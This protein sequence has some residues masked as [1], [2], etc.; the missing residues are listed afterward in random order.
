[1]APIISAMNKNQ[2]APAIGLS[3]PLQSGEV[4]LLLDI[5]EP[6]LQGFWFGLR[7]EIPNKGDNDNEQINASD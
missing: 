4:G 1:M 7:T 2:A 3:R 6:L 5:F